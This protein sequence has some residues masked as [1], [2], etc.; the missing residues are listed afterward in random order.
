V[1]FLFAVFLAGC[2]AGGSTT[3]DS[4]EPELLATVGDDSITITDVR[5]RIGEQLDRLDVQYR[6]SRHQLI[7]ET[8]Q[9]LLRDRLL[10]DEAAAKGITADELVRVEIEATIN[11]EKAPGMGPDDAPVT[12][13]EFSDFEC[14]FCARFYPT[15]KQLEDNYGDE[16]RIVYR[17]FPLENIHSYA[18]DAAEA[19][20]CAHE[21]GRFWE[22]HDL[23]FE[24]QD[25]LHIDALKEKARRLG[26]DPQAF[27]ACLESGQY[28]EQVQ[29][30]LREGASVG[31]RGTPALFVN[32][33]SVPGGAVPYETVA[34]EIDKALQRVGSSS[35]APLGVDRK[36][37]VTDDLVM[38][39]WRERDVV[40]HFDPFRVELNNDESP[41]VG[42]ASAK[43]TLVEFSDFECPFCGRF[44][45]TL[46]QLEENYGD[47]LRIVYRQFPIK[48]I[49]LY[50]F[51]AAEAS[52][53]AHEQ[54]RFW[55]MH[56]LLFEEQDQLDVDS[57]KEKAGLLGLDREAFDACLDS[58]QYT[59]QIQRDLSEGQS[60]GVTGTPALFVN[61]IFVPGG[62][63]PYET[64]AAAI[65]REL[66]RE[67]S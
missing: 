58:G 47:Q 30:D 61:G 17:Q 54:G 3:A 67:G 16:L 62:A 19:S 53:C 13:V 35:E 40:Y 5:E 7:E 20:L 28:T 65:D 59:D 44:Y 41:A 29:R 48:S 32:G 39:L 4:G 34:A 11:D 24:E 22:M 66:Q 49:H 31:V 56:D 18:F 37:K 15:L 42:P 27:D 36:N 25:Q 60:V 64:I 43:V 50:A 33:V 45:P 8:L 55:E 2:S 10:G 51:D 57:L 26:L 6:S 21:Q 63:V 1:Y 12:L 52:L 46:K 23:L 38:R 14:P 9:E